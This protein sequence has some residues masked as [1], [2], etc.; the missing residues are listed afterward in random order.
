MVN[1]HI[2]GWILLMILA[3]FL[4][5]LNISLS[6]CTW[7]LKN[8][9]GKIKFD[10]LDFH[11]LISNLIF[12]A[13]VACKNQLRNWFLKNL[14]FQKLSA[15]QQNV[16]LRSEIKAWTHRGKTI[17][18]KGH[19]LVSRYKILSSC[20]MLWYRRKILMIH[21]FLDHCLLRSI[22]YLVVPRT[23]DAQR[24]NSPHWMAKNSIPIPNL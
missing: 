20:T 19:N 6:I 2:S 7:F 15:D 12:S 14:I 16:P 1:A 18:V 13:C 4:E 23:T 11:L 10:K 22:V 17:E 9:V 3:L 8:Q 24:I 21:E 5:S